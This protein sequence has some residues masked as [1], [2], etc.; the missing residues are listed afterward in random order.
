MGD[1]WKESV[2]ADGLSLSLVAIL[3]CATTHARILKVCYLRK[4]LKLFFF[5]IFAIT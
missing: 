3:N 1:G 4:E 2:C 5:V